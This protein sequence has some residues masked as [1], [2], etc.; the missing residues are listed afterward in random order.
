MKTTPQK[1]QVPP[2]DRAFY[3]EMAAATGLAAAI[4]FLV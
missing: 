3:V 2:E 4:I 1:R